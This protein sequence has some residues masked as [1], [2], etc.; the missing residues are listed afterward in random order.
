MFLII[1]KIYSIKILAIYNEIWIPGFD[2]N[3]GYDLLATL[4]EQLGSC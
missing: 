1:V 3:V 4:P 2:S